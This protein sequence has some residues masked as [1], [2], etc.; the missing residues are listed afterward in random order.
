M[1]SKPPAGSS[2]SPRERHAPRKSGAQDKRSSLYLPLGIAAYCAIACLA[3]FLYGL[4]LRGEQ[5]VLRDQ[6]AAA[7]AALGSAHSKR[8]AAEV[9][10]RRE[11]D[12]Q[13]RL[14]ASYSGQQAVEKSVIVQAAKA[15]FEEMK[16]GEA[17]AQATAGQLRAAH[18]AVSLRWVPL[19]AVMLLHMFGLMLLRQRILAILA[20]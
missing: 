12:E 18:E 16:E 19:I 14:R 3:F 13:E 2:A 4:Q 5:S 11:S 7:D 20:R 9:V 1:S 17:Q 8:D 15:H 10:Y 6:L